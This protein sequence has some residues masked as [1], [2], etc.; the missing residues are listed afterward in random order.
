MPPLV[1]H[2]PVMPPSMPMGYDIFPPTQLF[3]DGTYTDVS[4]MSMHGPF[5]GLK[6]QAPCAWQM[7]LVDL[8]L[9]A[10]SAGTE[11]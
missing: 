3:P 1:P 9:R 10:Y 5:A 2:M 8:G 6:P 7:N 11:I 4:D